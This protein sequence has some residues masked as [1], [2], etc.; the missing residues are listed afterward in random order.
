MSAI[1]SCTQPVSLELQSG[2]NRP[3]LKSW[4]KKM[5]FSLKMACNFADYYH[6]KNSSSFLHWIEAAIRDKEWPPS[7]VCVQVYKCCWIKWKLCLVIA[8][9]VLSKIFELSPRG[10]QKQQIKIATSAS[11]ISRR[12]YVWCRNAGDI[13]LTSHSIPSFLI[14]SFWNTFFHKNGTLTELALFIVLKEALNFARRRGLSN[15]ILKPF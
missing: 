7:F 3:R 4:P 1:F 9:L 2:V 11:S 5:C 14:C 10:W 6:K 15:W 13:S 8:I 12:L